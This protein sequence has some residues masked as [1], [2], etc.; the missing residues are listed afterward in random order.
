MNLRHMRSLRDH[1]ANLP[2]EEFDYAAF[3]EYDNG[4]TNNEMPDWWDQHII[5]PIHTCNTTGCVAGHTLML[6][7]PGLEVRGGDYDDEAQKLLDLND[8]QTEFLFFA[9][10][11]VATL[12]DAIKRIEH[13]LVNDGDCLHYPWDKESWFD[14]EN[15][16]E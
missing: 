5:P 1:L 7:A 9:E 6:L 12:Q 15:E 3:L 4:L 2:P 10:S 11:G 16:P 14:E 8:Q 13:L